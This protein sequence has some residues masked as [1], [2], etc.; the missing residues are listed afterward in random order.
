MTN[1]P[2]WLPKLKRAA[3]ANGIALAEAASL[4][5]VLHDD[6]CARLQ[7]TGICDCDPDVRLASLRR[8]EDR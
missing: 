2:N 5:E 3:Q 8:E 4:A 6:D 7:G 1:Q